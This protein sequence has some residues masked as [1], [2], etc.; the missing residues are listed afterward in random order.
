MD[1]STLIGGRTIGG[2][3]HG[4]EVRDGERDNMA[5]EAEDDAAQKKGFC[6]EGGE[7]VGDCTVGSEVGGAEAEVHENPVRDGGV[8]WCR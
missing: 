2:N 5:V 1:Q 8:G 7:V 4:F 3:T 6:A